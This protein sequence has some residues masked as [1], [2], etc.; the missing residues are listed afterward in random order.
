MM[1][2]SGIDQTV[3]FDLRT[4][5]TRSYRYHRNICQTCLPQWRVETKKMLLFLHKC[6][7]VLA[8]GFDSFTCGDRAL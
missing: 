6:F 7:P 5:R 1:R 4:G 8:I 2:I 3:C